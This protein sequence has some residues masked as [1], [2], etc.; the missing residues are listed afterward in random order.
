[1]NRYEYKY[2]HIL[3]GHDIKFVGYMINLFNEEYERL[4][5]KENLFV[6]PFSNV[7]EQLKEYSNVVL[8]D[9]HFLYKKYS[10]KSKW[11]ISHGLANNLE[12]ILTSNTI[13]SK[14]IYRY[15]GGSRTTVDTKNSIISLA[16]VYQIIKRYIFK[17]TLE[18]FAAIGVANTTDIF[19]LSKISEKLKFYN[20]NYINNYDIL[21]KVKDES[22]NKSYMED[23]TLNVLL[24]HRG[25]EEGNH[26]EILKKL[27]NYNKENIKIFIPISYGDKDYIERV[28]Q[29]INANNF[30]KV[31]LIKD[32]LSFEEYSRLLI[33]MDIGIFDG[34]TS[35]AL[36]NI[37][38]LLMFGKTIYL[39][40]KG[41]IKEAFD[42]ES[43]PHKIINSIGEISF[44][45][46]SKCYK[47]DDFQNCGTSLFPPNKEKIVG[48]WERIFLD[49]Q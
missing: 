15:W 48:Y 29:Y 28:I 45:E 18:S 9:S 12:T 1:M 10:K 38:M 40:K 46:F 41:V 30:E 44:A 47:N 25:K 23:R 7:Y 4:N 6:T 21:K 8:D 20:I 39:N 43:V 27:S 49:F 13:K 16:N 31:V 35:Y 3:Y 19:D 37:A 5:L 2:V 11:I 42:F 22:E 24:G 26:I 32:F 34:Y 17:R 33:Q 14:I 36:G